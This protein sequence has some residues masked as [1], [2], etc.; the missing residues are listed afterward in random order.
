MKNYFVYIATNKIN[1]VFYTGMTNNLERRIYEHKNKLIPGFT[2]KYNIGKLIYYE[3]F[4][5][6]I[7]AIQAE[8]KIK[9]WSRAK[10][11]NLIRSKNPELED[12]SNLI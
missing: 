9:G 8:K 11:I 2:V 6:H 3:S 12:L 5:S 1:T 4:P 10:K 7:E